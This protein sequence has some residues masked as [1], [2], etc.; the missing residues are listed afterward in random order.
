MNGGDFVAEEEESEGEWFSDDDGTRRKRRPHQ[1][2]FDDEEDDDEEDEDEEP[3]AKKFCKDAPKEKVG[4]GSGGKQEEVAKMME[5][6]VKDEEKGT[7][8]VLP[9]PYDTWAMEYHKQLAS[10]RVCQ[11]NSA[12]GGVAAE[13]RV[14]TEDGPLLATGYQKT[15]ADEHGYYA[16]FGMSQLNREVADLQRQGKSK[17]SVE[18]AWTRF[19]GPLGIDVY[20]A[21]DDPFAKQTSAPPPPPIPAPSAASEEKKEKKGTLTSFFAVTHQGKPPP[22]SMAAAGKKVSRGGR[23]KHSK[24]SRNVFYVRV[25]DVWAVPKKQ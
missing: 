1:Q 5:E 23:K 16:Q 19:R 11:A 6:L 20:Y 18:Y 3:A 24:F 8:R 2:T 25:S 17:L 4:G 15:I 12:F 10:G 9:P 7:F 22:P 21:G 14:R 13:L